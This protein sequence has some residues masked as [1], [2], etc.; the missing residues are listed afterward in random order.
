MQL[1]AGYL[2]TFLG[3]GLVAA[4][5]LLGMAHRHPATLP[6]L[7]GGIGLAAVGMAWII[8]TRVRMWWRHG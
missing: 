4:G 7:I 6:M 2:L 3:L 1:A 5:W 8:V